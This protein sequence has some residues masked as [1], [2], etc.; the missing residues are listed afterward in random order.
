[1]LDDVDIQLRV[2]E[3]EHKDYLSRREVIHYAQWGAPLGWFTGALMAGWVR[4]PVSFA[5][6]GLIAWLLYDTI[7]EQRITYDL[8]L[9]AT[10]ILIK[11]LPVRASNKNLNP[12]EKQGKNKSL[13][14]APHHAKK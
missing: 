11:D 10:E 1:M 14:T 4:D 5:I 9:E 12:P 7:K 2:L 13:G 6:I 3:L 8:A